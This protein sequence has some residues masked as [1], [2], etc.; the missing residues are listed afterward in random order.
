MPYVNYRCLNSVI[1]ARSDTLL[2]RVS[3]SIDCWCTYLYRYTIHHSRMAVKMFSPIFRKTTSAYIVSISLTL[4]ECFKCRA[5]IIVTK[6]KSYCHK[7]DI[8]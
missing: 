8:D 2:Y 1:Y 5:V 6:S 7:F 4:S 3:V